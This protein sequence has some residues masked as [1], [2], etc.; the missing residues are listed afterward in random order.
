MGNWQAFPP[1]EIIWL[2]LPKSPRTIHSNAIGEAWPRISFIYDLRNNT[3]ENITNN[4]ANDGKPAWVGDKVYF[5]SDQA[6]NMRLN[7]WSYDTKTQTFGQI[8]EFDDFDISFMSAGSQD[9]VFEAGG[10]MYLMDLN[11]RTIQTCRR[12]ILSVIYQQKFPDP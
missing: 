5:L 12:S 4:H 1:M 8:T 3:A 10:Q 6:E 7:I 2:T 11:S 9:I